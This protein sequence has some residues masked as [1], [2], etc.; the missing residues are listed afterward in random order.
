MGQ[1]KRH[2]EGDRTE[3][4]QFDILCMVCH[5]FSHR[6]AEPTLTGHQRHYSGRLEM[7]S[8]W[9]V[10]S[11]SGML[12][13]QLA[14]PLVSLPAAFPWENAGLAD[15]INSTETAERTHSG[16]PAPPACSLP[17]SMRSWCQASSLAAQC[18]QT[19]VP[20]KILYY[21]TKIKKVLHHVEIENF[22]Q[23]KGI[24][25]LHFHF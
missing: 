23:D 15:C 21:W 22:Q 9:E 17:A 2:H 11:L 6:R 3:M 20:L 8:R 24:F 16:R 13:W 19:S 4:L 5:G 1:T 14:L 18:F 7:A 12:L 10:P 25:L